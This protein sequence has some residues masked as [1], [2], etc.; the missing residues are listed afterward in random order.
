MA[1]KAKGE[2]K[3]DQ[4]IPVRVGEYTVSV[5]RQD[6]RTAAAW[7]MNPV[8]DRYGVQIGQ[9]DNFCSCKDSMYRA[10]T[11]KHV[12]MVAAALRQIRQLVT[13]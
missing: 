12:G 11:C 9:F 8:G 10:R 13:A 6:G 2:A 4:P 3:Q 1:T 7:I 5:I